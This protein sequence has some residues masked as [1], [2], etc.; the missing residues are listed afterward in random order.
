MLVEP[1]HV[2]DLRFVPI[3]ADPKMLRDEV[4]KFVKNLYG[5][6]DYAAGNVTM[7]LGFYEEVPLDSETVGFEVHEKFLPWG[8]GNLSLS[9]SPKKKYHVVNI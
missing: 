8:W 9:P 5:F 4:F 2:D 3:P 7:L 1:F 6:G